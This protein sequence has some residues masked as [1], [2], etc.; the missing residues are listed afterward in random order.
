MI[1]TCL[2]ITI[3]GLVCAKALLWSALIVGLLYLCFHLLLQWGDKREKRR[4]GKVV[5]MEEYE[6]MESQR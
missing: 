2:T 3:L 1:R 6:P 4:Q 5:R